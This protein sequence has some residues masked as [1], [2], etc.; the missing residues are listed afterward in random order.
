MYFLC[1]HEQHNTHF[2]GGAGAGM[3]YVFVV[4]GLKDKDV[5]VL[6]IIDM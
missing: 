2:L 6:Y 4:S 1:I 3:T 5:D